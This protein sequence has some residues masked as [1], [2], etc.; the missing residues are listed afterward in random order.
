MGTRTTREC[1]QSVGDTPV[2]RE[3]FNRRER[4]MDI[5][6]V[7]YLTIVTKMNPNQWIYWKGYRRED[8]KSVKER[9]E[10][11]G[12]WKGEEEELLKQVVKK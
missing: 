7:V 10:R 1:F 9:K 11:L 12:S 8:Q 6:K 5:E 3:E 4:G 2:A